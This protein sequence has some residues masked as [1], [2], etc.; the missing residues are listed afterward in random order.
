VLFNAGAKSNLVN[1]SIKNRIAFVGRSTGPKGERLKLLFK[2]ALFH[3]LKAHPQIK[4]DIIANDPENFGSTFLE[5]L[6]AWR[7]P[8]QIRLLPKIKSIQDHYPQY[9]LVLGAGR[10]AVEA[11]LSGASV[12]SFGEFTSHGLVTEQNLQECLTSNFGDIGPGEFEGDPRLDIVISDLQYFYEED[13][14]PPS[15]HLRQILQQEFDRNLVAAQVMET[16][17]AALFKNSYP[18]WVPHLMYHRVPETPPQTQHRIFVTKAKFQWHL[19]IFRLLGFQSLHFSEILDFW[20]LKKPYSQFP[21]K[22]LLITF[23]DGYADNLENVLP[24][25]EQHRIKANLFLLA[26]KSITQ[27]NWDQIEGSE[28][29]AK[30]LD[31]S[32]RQKISKS[33]W[34][35]IGSHGNSHV[36]LTQLSESE[37]F[38]DLLTSKNQLEEEFSKPI[39]TIAFPFG[40]TNS[41]VAKLAKKA[42][43][44]FGVNTD[45]GGMHF[46]D[47]RW[48]QFR[49]NIFPED[50]IFTLWKKTSTWYRKRFFKKHQR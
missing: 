19:K 46:S 31:S 1:S 26:D 41:T 29:P 44:E 16:Y 30:L 7:I 47:D 34:I 37:I 18:H 42:G 17:K 25:L 49:V 22:P 40:R 35:E 4:I 8:G 5:E 21:K 10:V 2:Q 11:L 15:A 3:F 50:N 24:A 12:I 45:Q 27:N 13:A 36:D 43:Y 39:T 20:N 14:A 32:Q 6:H 33:P 28:P 48:S 23:D 38:Q 9:D